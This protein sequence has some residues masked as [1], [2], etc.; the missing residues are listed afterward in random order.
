MEEYPLDVRTNTIAYGR[1]LV[2][3]VESLDAIKE[4]TGGFGWLEVAARRICLT[5]Y[6][7]NLRRLV[8]ELPSELTAEI[9]AANEGALGKMPTHDPSLN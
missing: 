7:F 4:H 3:A 5:A 1:A 8:A 9:L 6:R 2:R